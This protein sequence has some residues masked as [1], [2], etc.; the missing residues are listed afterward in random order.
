M[1]DDVGVLV[2]CGRGWF[3]RGLDLPSCGSWRKREELGDT[4]F[5]REEVCNEEIAAKPLGNPKVRAAKS[6]QALN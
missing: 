3:G 6:D 1:L 5:I 2:C 4:A